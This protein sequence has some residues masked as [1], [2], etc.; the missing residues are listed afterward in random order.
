MEQALKHQ[1]H[2]PQGVKQVFK[3]DARGQVCTP[4]LENDIKLRVVTRSRGVL[5]ADDIHIIRK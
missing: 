5:S 1:Q 3:I 4:Q 2:L